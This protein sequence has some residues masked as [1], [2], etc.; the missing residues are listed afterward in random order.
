MFGFNGNKTQQRL[1]S[2]PCY[3]EGGHDWEVV[4]R[5]EP[6]EV[7]A[8]PS[9][10]PRMGDQTLEKRVCL[11]CCLIDDQIEAYRRCIEA[12]GKQHTERQAM[13]AEIIRRA[14]Q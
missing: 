14:G 4:Q 9:R 3:R 2:E 6:W 1:M 7:H 12:I 13:A 5:C 11:R 10:P 8:S